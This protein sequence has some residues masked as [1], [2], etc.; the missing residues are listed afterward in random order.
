MTI[1]RGNYYSSWHQDSWI[2]KTK[3]K[4]GEVFIF[5][6]SKQSSLQPKGGGNATSR[7]S[8]AP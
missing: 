4:M 3:Q 2:F 1:L 5:F 7:L 6:F 8:K